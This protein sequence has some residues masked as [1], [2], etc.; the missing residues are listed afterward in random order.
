MEAMA[1]HVPVVASNI[2]GIPELVED[3]RSG[4]L[5]APGNAEILAEKIRTLLENENLRKSFSEN[6]YQKVL[7]DFN[8]KTVNERN[9]T[10]TLTKYSI[11]LVSRTPRLIL[12]K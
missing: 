5:V 4:F 6:G 9:K 3:G 10:V 8:L 11:S 1:F 7:K 12:L 2:C